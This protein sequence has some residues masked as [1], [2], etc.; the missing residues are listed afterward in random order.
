M[1]LPELA[2]ARGI[3]DHLNIGA[4]N[5]LVSV[6]LVLRQVQGVTRELVARLKGK[7]GDD[8]VD[9]G[10]GAFPSLARFV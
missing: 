1:K 8:V 3:M 2:P 6:G 10:V 4:T 5:R 7:A 9:E